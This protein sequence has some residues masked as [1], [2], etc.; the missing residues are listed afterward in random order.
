MLHEIVDVWGWMDSKTFMDGIALGQVTPGPIVITST[1]VGYLLYG[2]PGAI[3]ATLAIFTPSFMLVLA[4][5]PVF[6]KLK[7]S[8]YFAGATKG[9]LASFV[10][11]LFFVSVKFALD[12]QW[13]VP[14][15]LI[16]LAAFTALFRKVDVI[17]VVLIGS[18]ISVII[19]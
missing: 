16:G 14:R 3:V 17:Y 11:L 4:M 19:F 13:D 18:I 8:A 10:G 6:D 12:V 15:M 5:T 9:I 7:A 1:F 2:L